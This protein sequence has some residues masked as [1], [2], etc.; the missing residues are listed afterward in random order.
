MTGVSDE[1]D[2]ARFPGIA[3]NLHVHLRHQRT[4]GVEH[5]ELALLGLHLHHTRHAVRAEDHGRP[6]R[7]FPQLLHEHGADRAQPIHDVLVVHDLVSD[8]DRRSEQIDGALD[9][10]DG[11]V[12]TCAKSPWIGQ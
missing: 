10:V 2:L 7:H 11:P 4:G 5:V 1:E 8:V 9:D 6:V 3:R 12:D